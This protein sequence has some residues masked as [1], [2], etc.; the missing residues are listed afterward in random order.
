MNLHTKP[1]FG[2]QLRLICLRPHAKKLLNLIN[3]LRR[4]KNRFFVCDEQ[5][6]GEILTENHILCQTQSM[7]SSSKYQNYSVDEKLIYLNIKSN[8]YQQTFLLFT[9][10]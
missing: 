5:S 4:K 6:I 8:G 9:K 7:R 2:F 1:I 3:T 10:C